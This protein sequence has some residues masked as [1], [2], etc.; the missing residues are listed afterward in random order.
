M[1]VFGYWVLRN[2]CQ[3][4]VALGT[5]QYFFLAVISNIDIAQQILIS[6]SEQARGAKEQ[7]GESS[8]A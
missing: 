6:G 8:K 3:K 4:L 2:I 1:L 5:G 7:K